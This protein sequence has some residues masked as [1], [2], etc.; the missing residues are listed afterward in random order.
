[1]FFQSVDGRDV[2]M[3]ERGEQFRVA[4]EAGQS[5]GIAREFFRGRVDR[6]LAAELRVAGAPR[7]ALL[8]SLLGASIAGRIA[9]GPNAGQRVR[10]AGNAIE[11]RY[12]ETLTGPRCA[13]VAGFSLHANVAVGAVDRAG[14]ERLCRYAGRG[15]W[16][17]S[18][19]PAGQT[20][21]WPTG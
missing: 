6:D 19:S 14:L 15:R 18:G 7:L 3:V 13:N 10:M 8:A 20:A 12:R 5:V 17:A 11:D 2:G 9:T 1:M 16:P 21:G 4:L